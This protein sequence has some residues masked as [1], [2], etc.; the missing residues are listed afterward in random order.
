[1]QCHQCLY[2][3][4]LHEYSYCSMLTAVLSSKHITLNTPTK[5]N[6][7]SRIHSQYRSVVT[8]LCFQQCVLVLELLDVLYWLIQLP[9]CLRALGQQVWQLS[10]DSI[11]LNILK[12]SYYISDSI[13]YLGY[14]L[15]M[16][17]L[18]R[19]WPVMV[20]DTHTR[21]R[22]D[23]SRSNRFYINSTVLF[24]QACSILS[25]WVEV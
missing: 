4:I 11:Q 2:I 22:S 14:T 19:G 17:T 6:V 8:F 16:K 21:R 24:I 13:A 12:M 15:R 5:H 23:S 18:F 7:F 3:S 20:H 10:T 1:V 25:Q 9:L